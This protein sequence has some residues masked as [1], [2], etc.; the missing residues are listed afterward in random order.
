M[1][2]VLKPKLQENRKQPTYEI[3]LSTYNSTQQNPGHDEAYLAIHVVLFVE[4]AR[5]ANHP[6]QRGT[7]PVYTEYDQCQGGQHCVKFAIADCGHRDDKKNQRYK[8]VDDAYGE[9]GPANVT[10][11]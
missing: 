11:E 2:L 3:S 9:G 1:P 5:I 4:K 6:Q 7:K 8:V 10:V